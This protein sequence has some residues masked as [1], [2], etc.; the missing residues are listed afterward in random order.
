MKEYTNQLD[1][2]L[3]LRKLIGH[4]PLIMVG[5]CTL[6]RNPEGQ[7]LFLRRTDNAA[8]GIPGGALEPGETLEQ[9]AIRETYEESGLQVTSLSLFDLFSGPE[10]YYEYP[11]GDQVYNVTAVYL[12]H[13]FTG[14]LNPNPSEHQTAGF[15]DLSTLP[16]PISQPIRP[17]I[18]KFLQTLR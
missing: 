16:S 18:K 3:E 6:I 13:H 4:R 10:F 1:Y 2:I 14:T 12:V 8:W 9:A 5:A 11:N 15:F 17:I 7:L